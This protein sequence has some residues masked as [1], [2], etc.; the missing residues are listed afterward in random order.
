MKMT[1]SRN[2]AMRCISG[3]LIRNA[4]RSSMKV[5]E[6]RYTSTRHGRC[7]TERSLAFTYSCGVMSAKPLPYTAATAVESANSPHDAKRWY[8]NWCAAKPSSSGLRTAI[9]WRTAAASAAACAPVA[10]DACSRAL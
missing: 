7:A 8:T 2:T 1:S 3:I 9:M 10:A 6:K 5:L 4:N